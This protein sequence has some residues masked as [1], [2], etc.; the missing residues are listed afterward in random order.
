MP[1]LWS[2]NISICSL[3]F[4][5]C[6][7]HAFVFC[8]LG[9]FL[10]FP[11]FRSAHLGKGE[12][13]ISSDLQSTIRTDRGGLRGLPGPPIRRASDCLVP[14]WVPPDHKKTTQTKQKHALASLKGGGL[15]NYGGQHKQI[16]ER[17]FFLHFEW[18]TGKDAAGF[19]PRARSCLPG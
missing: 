16:T 11:S 19:A 12:G 2:P 13:G 8:V 15:S 9:A 5:C 7:F 17:L 10:G 18:T 14:N 6:A 4:A 3:V 1:T